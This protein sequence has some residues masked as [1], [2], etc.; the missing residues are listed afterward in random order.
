VLIAKQI[1]IPVST[2]SD[3]WIAAEVLR[4]SFQLAQTASDAV[5]N[6]EELDDTTE[7]TVELASL[8]L[9]HVARA[10][11]EDAQSKTAR[12]QVL[13]NAF[14][15]FAHSYLGQNDVHAVT[16]SFDVEIR[17]TVLSTYYLAL[18]TLEAQNVQDIP[19]ARL[20][21][22]FEATADGKASAYALFGGQ[23]TNEVYFDELQTL[24]DVYH[25][26]VSSFL[27]EMASSVLVP[28]TEAATVPFYTHG[29][30]VLAWLSGTAP[31]PSVDYLASVPLSMPLIGL[32]QLTQY[33][34]SCRVAGLTPGEMR[35]HFA[36]TT[37]HSQGV[38]SA[39]AISA[40]D[41]FASFVT[42]AKKCLTW[43]FFCGLRG[44]EAFPVV[45]L[46]PSMVKDSLDGGEGAP[47]PM[48]AVSGLS[49]VDL[50]KHIG[51]TNK[52]LPENSRLGVSLHNGSKRFVVTGP[53][54]ALFGLVTSL[55]KVRAP[56]DLDQSKI[57]FSQRKPVFS[58][59]F[60]A[61]GVPYHSHYL[62]DGVE[63]ML[64][65]DLKGEE[66]W[67]ANE[68]AIPVYHTESGKLNIRLHLS[69]LAVLT[70]IDRRRSSKQPRLDHPH[71]LRAGSH[72]AYSLGQGCGVRREG[73]S[74]GRLRSG[75]R[76]RHRLT[77]GQPYRGS[78]RPRRCRR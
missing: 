28:L 43:L 35:S 56:T 30:E 44:Q 32:T 64:K 1:A 21:A 2:K 50:E 37:G 60:L 9:A 54:K 61:V 29:M 24:F 53:P 48:L 26:F 27:E 66:L 23:G 12:T 47:T 46:E 34:I 78:W 17:R 10:V 14:K 73:H 16:L 41:S 39:V 71:A 36:G 11:D 74:C 3:E 42:N 40:S 70:T 52:H 13:L 31:R 38:V 15:H 57:P 51:S 77:H 18:S 8:F 25:P 7:A 33:L 76:V 19:R 45:A 20:P 75:R 67:K 5:I 59:R 68:L 6:A 63:K 65:T 55:R 22:L 69:E 58:I 72:Y 49:L 4:E 62:V